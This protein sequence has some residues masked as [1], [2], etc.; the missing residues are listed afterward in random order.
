MKRYSQ[1]LNKMTIAIHQPNFMP[2]MGYFYKIAKS[3]IFVLLDDVQYT[4]GGF[5]N[6]NR[7]KT[8]NGEQWLTLNVNLSG[9]SFQSINKIII[10]NKDKTLSKILKTIQ[11][12]YSKAE[13]FK[14]YFPELE[15]IVIESN[16]YLS[17]FNSSIIQWVKG[18]FNI[19]T[20]IVR[21]SELNNIEGQ[22]TDRLVSICNMLKAS[23]YLSGKGGMNY[24]DEANFK[25]NNIEL[26]ITNFNHPVYNQLYGE[27]IPNLS[28]I[29][30]IFNCGPD[31]LKTVE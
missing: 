11:N 23:K 10:F 30:F 8:P 22:S 3:D 21:S 7:I 9:H 24:Q 17:E 12:N 1:N 27:F 28:I 19:S 4:K 26:E 29:D 20:K 16:D 6:R 13:Y 2:W 15:K 25:D 5:T 14:S 31:F 18:L